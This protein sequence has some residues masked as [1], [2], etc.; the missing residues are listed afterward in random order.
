MSQYWLIIRQRIVPLRLL[1]EDYFN[2]TP[3]QV[4][5]YRNF[6]KIMGNTDVLGCQVVGGPGL[7]GAVASGI[8]AS[9]TVPDAIL[10]PPCLE[11]SRD[12]STSMYV[13]HGASCRQLVERFVW[14]KT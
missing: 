4:E 8:H 12:T 10:P 6:K 9:I 14:N 13:V 1:L 11:S 2:K 7:L 3:Q 5:K